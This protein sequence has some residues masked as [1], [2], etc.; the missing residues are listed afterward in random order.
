MGLVIFRRCS[1]VT[2]PISLILS[3]GC[4]A[5]ASSNSYSDLLRQAL[6]E[7]RHAAGVFDLVAKE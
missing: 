3:V 6:A 1:A 2:A 5:N 7:G 4:F